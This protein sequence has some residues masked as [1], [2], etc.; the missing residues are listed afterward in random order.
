MSN[1]Q[2]IIMKMNKLKD[3]FDDLKEVKSD[4]HTIFDSLNIKITKLKSIYQ[5]FLQENQNNLFVFGLDSFKFQNKLIDN[6]YNNMRN[7]YNLITNR[8]YCDYYKLHNIVVEFISKNVDY[9][10]VKIVVKDSENKYEKYNYL[11]IYKHYEFSVTTNIFEDTMSYIFSLIDYLKT[12]GLQLD[13]YNA[14]KKN[15]LNIHNFV[16]TFA[17]NRSLLE[18]QI[19]LYINYLDFFLKLHTKYLMQFTE[20]ITVMYNQINKDIQFEDSTVTK[21][22]RIIRGLDSDSDRNSSVNSRLLSDEEASPGVDFVYKTDSI[23]RKSLKD[24]A[25][26]INDENEVNAGETNDIITSS[27]E[28]VKKMSSRI[29][30]EIINNVIVKHEEDNEDKED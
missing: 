13:T 9:E 16:Y 28:Y 11:D 5:E 3:S 30:T 10:K 22:K 25:F 23:Q 19:H 27:N 4:I 20:K 29:V 14:K 24:A 7:F 8:M 12:L 1:L 15:G 18:E 21:R 2:D 26:K 17:Y 6:E